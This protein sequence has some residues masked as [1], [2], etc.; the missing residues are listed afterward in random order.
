MKKLYHV[1]VVWGGHVGCEVSLACAR[2]GYKILLVTGNIKNVPCNP[3]IG[4]IAEGL[5]ARKFVDVL[6]EEMGRNRFK[7]NENK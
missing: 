2:K 1:I 4:R 3:S 6:I 5:V 7:T